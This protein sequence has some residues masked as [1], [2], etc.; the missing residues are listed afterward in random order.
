MKLGTSMININ[1][2][3]NSMCNVA[4]ALVMAALFSFNS[5][6]MS[7]A[8]SEQILDFDKIVSQGRGA[9]GIGV[10]NDGKIVNYKADDWFCIDIGDSL[11]EDAKIRIKLKRLRSET[12]YVKVTRLT[13]DGTSLGRVSTSRMSRSNY[14]WTPEVELGRTSQ[15]VLC[16]VLRGARIQIEDI[17]ITRKENDKNDDDV[18]TDNGVDTSGSH[19]GGTK[20]EHIGTNVAIDDG[21]ISIKSHSGTR[22][23]DLLLLFVHRTDG[24]VLKDNFDGWKFLVKC[25]KHPTDFGKNDT[26]CN[27]N[28]RNTDLGQ[29]IFWRKASFLG[30]RRFNI[31]MSGSKPTWA[32][33][34]TLRNAN[35]SN[36]MRD[37][38]TRGCDHNSDSLFP[39]VEGKKGDLLILSQSFDDKASKNKFNAPDKATM[40]GYVNGGD[41]TGFLY[42]KPITRNGSTGELKT[43][44]DGASKCK[45]GLISLTIRD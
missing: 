1:R 12:G 36:P 45:D 21:D 19:S 14:E 2:V 41:E 10:R 28:G 39:S 37:A 40:R 3:K 7:L 44:G 23:D 20:I 33:I 15:K 29:T 16:F 35:T 27:H 30:E 4:F 38:E 24:P 22:P 9:R 11:G 34:T 5:P 32:M 42:T 31:D 25:E 8:A 43:R 17:A 13:E 6:T 18:G 26:H